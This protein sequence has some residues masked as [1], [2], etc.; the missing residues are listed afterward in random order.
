MA[1]SLKHVAA[2]AI[3]VSRDV[4]HSVERF[5]KTAGRKIDSAR[6]QTGGALH[7]VASSMR[8]SSAKVE[9]LGRNAAKRLDTA[10]SFV[11]NADFKRLY[12]GLR[13]FAKEHPTLTLLAGTVAGCWAGSTLSRVMRARPRTS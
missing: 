7:A 13:G 4:K 11:E 9:V 10:A 12:R 1:T 3:D 8:R 5:G 2:T 6:D